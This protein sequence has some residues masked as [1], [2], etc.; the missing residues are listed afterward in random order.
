MHNFHVSLLAN[1]SFPK[2][3]D[4]SFLASTFKTRL[5]M[6]GGYSDKLIV[7]S[8]NPILG[9]NAKNQQGYRK[10]EF[11]YSLVVTGSATTN[12]SLHLGKFLYQTLNEFTEKYARSYFLYSMYVERADKKD[13]CVQ[14]NQERVFHV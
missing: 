9:T 1:V 11:L 7:V 14:S 5:V 2:P 10:N 3:V 6:E 8:L 4:C 13:F 12:T